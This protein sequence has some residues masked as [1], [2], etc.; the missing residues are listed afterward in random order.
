MRRN[1]KDDDEAQLGQIGVKGG[2]GEQHFGVGINFL[3]L[4]EPTECLKAFS[5]FE[6]GEVLLIAPGEERI[7]VDHARSPIQFALHIDWVH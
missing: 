4:Y 2:V 6:I 1:E 7:G 3:L 5:E